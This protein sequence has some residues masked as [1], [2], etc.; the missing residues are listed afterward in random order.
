MTQQNFFDPPSNPDTRL[1]AAAAIAPM[2][3]NM[4]RLVLAFIASPGHHGATDEEIFEATGLRESTARAR[5]VELQESGQVRS[6]NT[7]RVWVTTGTP[8]DTAT[9]DSP[10][11]PEPWPCEGT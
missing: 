6:G 8:L 3:P 5:R 11:L 2:T 4:R 10:P 7:A 9:P 1:A